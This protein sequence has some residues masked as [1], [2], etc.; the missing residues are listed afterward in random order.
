MAKKKA[1]AQGSFTFSAKTLRRMKRIGPE[2]E[3]QFADKVWDDISAVMDKHGIT[4]IN[5]Q[6]YNATK[7]TKK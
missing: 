3:D 5:V 2:K 6:D 7:K 4:A 1:E